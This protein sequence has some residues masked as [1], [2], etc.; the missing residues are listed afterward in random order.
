MPWRRFALDSTELSKP[1]S[2]E[3]IFDDAEK[4]QTDTNRDD[5]LTQTSREKSEDKNY[6]LA[7]Y[8][9]DEQRNKNKNSHS[10]SESDTDDEI[11]RINQSKIIL[12]VK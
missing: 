9:E 6:T 12:N 10:T 5:N 2:D 7:L 8:D 4:I 3:E 1:E 11:N